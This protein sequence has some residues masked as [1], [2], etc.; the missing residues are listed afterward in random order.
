MREI[1]ITIIIRIFSI[2]DMRNCVI[3]CPI[4]NTQ[5]GKR[6]KHFMCVKSKFQ[7]SVPAG[8]LFKINQVIK[9]TA[10]T[11]KM[12]PAIVRET[13]QFLCWDERK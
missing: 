7:F 5:I 8:L 3:K 9:R 1:V 2:L 10:K 6:T 4:Q 11:M 13:I 12:L